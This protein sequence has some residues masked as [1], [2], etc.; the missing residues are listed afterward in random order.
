MTHL[1]YS[2][3]KSGKTFNLQK[4]IMKTEPNHNEVD[5]NIYKD[6]KDE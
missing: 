5:C 1:K 3:K 4:E 2:L 6:K